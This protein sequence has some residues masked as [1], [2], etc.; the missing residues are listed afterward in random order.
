MSVS[1]NLLR[2]KRPYRLSYLAIKNTNLQQ[3]CFCNNLR[4]I[5]V[6][7]KFRIMRTAGAAAPVGRRAIR[8]TVFETIWCDV[9]FGVF[10]VGRENSKRFGCA[11]GTAAGLAHR[12]LNLNALG[13]R[14]KPFDFP[15]FDEKKS[16]EAVRTISKFFL[17]RPFFYVIL[18]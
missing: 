3:F 8:E 10:W 5:T 15:I 7:G 12:K 4:S 1:N 2:D 13:V 9:I 14:V 17:L 18:H 6:I 11:R 16:S